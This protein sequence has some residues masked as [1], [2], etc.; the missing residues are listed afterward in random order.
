MD[1]VRRLRAVESA[2][3][4]MPG[5]DAERLDRL[6]ASLETLAHEMMRE[7]QARDAAKSRGRKRAQTVRDRQA[8][9]E[10]ASI[11]QAAHDAA[12]RLLRRT[13]YR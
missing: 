7:R 13:G 5:I 11:T 12:E 6:I 10:P 4:V 8:A 2:R 1:D 3:E 9:G